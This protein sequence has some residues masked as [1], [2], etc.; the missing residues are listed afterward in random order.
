MTE[1]KLFQRLGH[2][3]YFDNEDMDLYFHIPLAYQNF[4]GADFGEC[5]YAASRIKQN[6]SESWCR[7]WLTLA[8]R[9]EERAHKALAEGHAISAHAAYLHA[10]TYYRTA[11]IAMASSDPR[12]LDVVQAFKV[13]FGKAVALSQYNVESIE[14]PFRGHNLPGY[15]M[16]GDGP[17]DQKPTLISVNGSEMF[18]EEHYF[19]T[20]VAGMQRGYNVISVDLPGESGIRFADPNLLLKDL[21]LTE[22]ID[23]DMILEPVVTYAVA[24]P[25]V[26]AERLA[27][28]GYSGGG[29]K[30][31]RLA[32]YNKDV[33]A[34]VADAPI[35]DI[36]RITSSEMPKALLNLP[37][38]IGN[39][40]FK[41]ASNVNPFTKIT[42]ERL[43]WAIGLDSLS[44]F[45]ELTRQAKFEPEQIACPY[46]ALG[47]R[48][49]SEEQNR[50]ANYVYD[51]V[52]SQ[53]KGLRFFTAEEGADGHCQLNNLTLMQQ[54]IFDW[55]DDVFRG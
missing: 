23:Y 33:K 5:F 44:D 35:Y 6:D 26:D 8:T 28:V 25:K 38:F 20:G 21:V 54:V 34:C 52:S 31:S 4:G 16:A 42:T 50:Q 32:A 27:I 18:A 24:H 3:I 47:S 19:W 12:L 55:L 46:L 43:L 37:N 45:V 22:G 40:I 48:G 15:F 51:H 30:V 53:V 29:Y 11:Q 7:E 39:A 1:E 2:T 10:F 13:A 41:A 14:I 49:E 36:Y 17:D 9:A